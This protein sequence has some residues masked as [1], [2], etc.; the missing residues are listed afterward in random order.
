MKKIKI[1]IID[2]CI[3]DLEYSQI[4]EIRSYIYNKDKSRLL[5]HAEKCLN[6]ILYEA[7]DVEIYISEIFNDGE[8]GNI[9]TLILALKDYL[10][11]SIDIINLS[12]TT[13]KKLED[14]DIKELKKVCFQLAMK[15]TLII[16]SAN[17]NKCLQSFPAL[18]PFVIGVKGLCFDSNKYWYNGKYDIQMVANSTPSLTLNSKQTKGSFFGGNS[19]ATALATG[20]LASMMGK[21]CKSNIL[22][23]IQEQSSKSY[24][25]E[26]DLEYYSKKRDNMPKFQ[27]IEELYYNIHIDHNNK[28]D[29]LEL[30]MTYILYNQ[31][32]DIN[33]ILNMIKYI[34][35]KHKIKI[36]LNKVFY[37]DFLDI[38]K[39][40]FALYYR[41]INII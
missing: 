4:V 18:F 40:K 7:A 29:Y 9:K 15:G 37:Y 21:F 3:N 34:E 20:I 30:L 31:K 17:N 22:E 2:S 41:W 12:L 25:D 14:I 11:S 5:T 38:D 19:K 10:G 32:I 1:A 28:T 24:W 26:Y 8:N 16:A 36:N 27:K 33:Y 39:L 23:K 13:I 6:V 35:E